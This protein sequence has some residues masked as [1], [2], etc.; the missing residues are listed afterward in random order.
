MKIKNRKLAIWLV[1]SLQ[2]IFLFGLAG[3]YYA[4]DLMGEEV[5]LETAPVDPRDLFY[6]DYVNLGYEITELPRHLLRGQDEELS[7]IELYDR[8]VYVQL[9]RKENDVTFVASNVYLHKKDVPNG[10]LV[11]QGRIESVN[12]Q[13]VWLRYGLE[14]YYVPEGTGLELEEKREGM[15]VKIKIAPWGQAKISELTWRDAL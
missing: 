3:S 15:L 12:K 1:I 2:V 4:V 14:R 9:E 11:L 7:D 10:S 6:G 5:V 13:T 8:P